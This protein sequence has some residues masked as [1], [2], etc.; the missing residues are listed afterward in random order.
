[1][2]IFLVLDGFNP[3]MNFL[4]GRYSPDGTVTFAGLKGRYIAEE[5]DPCKSERD[6]VLGIRPE[7][8]YD[9]YHAQ[10]DDTWGRKQ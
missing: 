1:M 9:L 10:Y 3:T 8:A 7:Y 5:G 4:D 2:M 6:V